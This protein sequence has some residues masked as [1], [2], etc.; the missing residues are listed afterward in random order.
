MRIRV[1]TAAL[2]IGT[3]LGLTAC[4]SNGPASGNAGGSPGSKE[5]PTTP[6]IPSAASL[7]NDAM[8]ALSTA[9][10]VNLKGTVSENGQ[11]VKLNMAF[12]S[13]GALSG[14]ISGPFDGTHL[15]ADVI[16]VGQT[17]YVLI[18]KQYFNSVLRQHGV[19]ASACAVYCGKY[20]KEPARQLKGLSLTRLT[21]RLFASTTVFS[22][23][24]TTATIDGQPT[25]RIHDNKGEYLY[26]TRAAPH[27]PIE[28]TKPG[29]GTVVFSEWNSVPPISPPPA[30]KILDL[31]GGKPA[32]A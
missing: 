18:D 32:G 24:G 20:L 8:T 10:S 26:V 3:L 11:V 5:T 13:S 23:T 1:L 31:S 14:S 17:A 29:T 6:A 9:V 4:G 22:G 27:R 30:S 16:V 12:T 2:V 7:A 19:P 15:A 25:Y 28:V 21:S